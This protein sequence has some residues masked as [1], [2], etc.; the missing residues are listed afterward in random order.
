MD[1]GAWWAAVHGAAKSWKRL[2][3]FTFTFHFHALEKDRN[4][5]QCSCLENPRDGGAWWAANYGVTQ[6]RTRL[7]WLSS[8]SSSRTIKGFVT[9]FNLRCHVIRASLVAQMV[10]NLPAMQETWVWVTYTFISNL[11]QLCYLWIYI[12]YTY[13]CISYI[14]VCILYY[15]IYNPAQVLLTKVFNSPSC[16][17]H[18]PTR[19]L[20]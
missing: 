16:L 6:I 9:I 11:S 15:T 7:R 8:S 10:K 5:L 19:Q 17:P 4:P 1:R 18:S 12:Y 20:L 2:N 3:D 14:L 13:T